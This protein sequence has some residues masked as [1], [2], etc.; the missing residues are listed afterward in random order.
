M[1]LKK[2]DSIETTGHFVW[3]LSSVLLSS[4]IIVFFLIVKGVK[5]T[6]KI[7]Y[8][9]TLFPYVVLLIMGIKGWCLDG[10]YEGILFY[11]KPNIDKLKD[12]G[13]R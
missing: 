7:V 12:I 10:A 6:G 2:S 9:T 3:Q 11:I 4:W 1:I 13:V 5:G 8:F